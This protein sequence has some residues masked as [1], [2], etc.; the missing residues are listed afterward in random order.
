MSLAVIMP[1]VAPPYAPGAA[2]KL[3]SKIESREVFLRAVE[4]YAQR[5]QYTERVLVAPPD[6][7]GDLQK[8]SANLGFQGVAL[9]GGTSDWLGCVARG[10]EKLTP[11][12]E[13]VVVHD[14]ARVS[15]PFFLLDALEAALTENPKA[16]GAVPVLLTNAAFAEVEKQVGDFVDMTAVS[17]IQSPQIFRRKV[18]AEAH[19]KRAAD[20]SSFMDDAELVTSI[21]GK[22]VTV[23]G[24]RFNQ[25]VDSDEMVRIAKHLIET[26]PKPKPKTPLNPFGEAQW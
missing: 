17:E 3:L 19:A 2:N 22:I 12:I 11:A 9:T 13:Q 20:K 23:P 21:G 24:S 1:L 26:M 16:A 15:V 25:R 5:D 7:L 8:Y 10:L 4:L 14:P 6:V 18:L